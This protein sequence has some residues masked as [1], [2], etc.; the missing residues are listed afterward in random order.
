MRE[1]YHSKSFY[2]FLSNSI[3]DV[4]EANLGE[5]KPSRVRADVGFQINKFNTT[6]RK[7]WDG[8]RKHDVMF[9]LTIQATEKSSAKLQD[10]EDFKEHYGIKYIRGCE[11]VDIIGQ[12]GRAIDENTRYTQGDQAANN[13]KGNERTIRLELDPNQYKVR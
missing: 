4:A 7:E 2:L 1:C 11:I 13:F 5:E 3:V 6:I 12:D 10:D 8:L 9:L